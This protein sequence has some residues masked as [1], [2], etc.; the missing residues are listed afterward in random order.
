MSGLMSSDVAVVLVGAV[1]TDMEVMV[2]VVATDVW[3]C[4]P[5]GLGDASTSDRVWGCVVMSNVSVLIFFSGFSTDVSVVWKYIEEKI[6]L[7]I[8]KLTIWV[9]DQV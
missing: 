8:R 3:S 9:F 7:H 2:V 4:S 5:A 6:S 1:V